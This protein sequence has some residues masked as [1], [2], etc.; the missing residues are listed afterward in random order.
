VQ[1]MKEKKIKPQTL[2]NRAQARELLTNTNAA[3]NFNNLFELPIIFYVV[4]LFL[5]VKN[6]SNTI[7]LF[8]A[9]GFVISRYIHSYI[10]CT[11]NRV[12]HRFYAFFVSVT[13]LFLIVGHT[14]YLSFIV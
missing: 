4:M 8:L 11:Y 2:A 13:F 14:L 6:Q 9:W 7:S 1:E 5:M 12:M 3:D 10:H